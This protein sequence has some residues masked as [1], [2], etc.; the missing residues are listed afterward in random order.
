MEKL[1]RNQSK[2]GDIQRLGV[3]IE[4]SLANCKTADENEL[5]I[6]VDKLMNY[7]KNMSRNLLPEFKEVNFKIV[8]I[9]HHSQ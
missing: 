3:D 4:R 6:Y 7:V 2:Y 1:N 5:F 9:D 8:F